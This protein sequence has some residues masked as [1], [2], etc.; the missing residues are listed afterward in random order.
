[1]ATPRAIALDLA[2]SGNLYSLA[3]TLVGLLLRHLGNPFKTSV[4]DPASESRPVGLR[5][6]AKK[7]KAWFLLYLPPSVKTACADSPKKFVY[8]GTTHEAG[9]RGMLLCTRFAHNAH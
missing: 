9:E 6:G 1:M 3:Q 4:C 8:T 7:I 5:F 2:G